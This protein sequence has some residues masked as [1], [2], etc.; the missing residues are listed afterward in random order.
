MS[1]DRPQRIFRRSFPPLHARAVGVLLGVSLAAAAGVSLA[2]LPRRS[3]APA[4]AGEQ[5]SAEPEQVA[6][7]DAGTL[8]LGDRVVRLRGVEPPLHSTP[9]SDEDCGAAAANALAA[10]V[11]D[12]PVVC[13]VVGTDRSGRPYGVCQAD[14]TELSQAVVAAGW[15]R[16]QDDTPGLRAAEKTARAEKRGVWAHNP[17][18]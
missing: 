1:L 16:A 8:R 18:W 4:T 3:A 11:R 12:A 9:C 17:I 7:I 5:L 6:V 2:T 14:G 15:A 13:R 10:M